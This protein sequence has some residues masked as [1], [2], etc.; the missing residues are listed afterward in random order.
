[1]RSLWI[2]VGITLTIGI[3]LI[4][5][6]AHASPES[7]Y[8][9]FGL[10]YG[11]PR[12][13]A[14]IEPSIDL[15]EGAGATNLP[16]AVDLGLYWPIEASSLLGA[17]I[18]GISDSYTVAASKISLVQTGIFFSGMHF[19]GSEPGKGLFLRGDA[20]AGR[21]AVDTNLGIAGGSDYGFGGG[22]AIGFGLPLGQG[23][24]ILFQASYLY[25]RVEGENL[26]AT[27]FTIG[28]LF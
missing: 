17:S 12:Y 2:S 22:G 25:R 3:S 16:I 15:L 8:F 7:W 20:G 11:I 28:G 10:G 5:Q 21:F 6:A 23:T 9:N 13:P 14:N 24:R 19:F 26:G 18:N 27:A 1:M 4:S